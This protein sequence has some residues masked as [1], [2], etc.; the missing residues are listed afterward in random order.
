MAADD[1]ELSLFAS[2]FCFILHMLW[3]VCELI[4]NPYANCTT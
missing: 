3:L 2:Y 1:G 4:G